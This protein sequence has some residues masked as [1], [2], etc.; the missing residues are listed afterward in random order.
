MHTDFRN[1]SRHKSWADQMYSQYLQLHRE[2]GASISDCLGGDED[3]AQYFDEYDAP[4]ERDE[5]EGMIAVLNADGVRQVLSFL[6][7]QNRA[8]R[9][10]H[11]RNYA[12]R[13]TE[14]LCHH[15]KEEEAAGNAA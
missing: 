5:F 3:L 12:I 6:A 2:T 14:R 1:Q 9:K 15:Q 10:V 7:P 13:I 4:I 8:A 11:A